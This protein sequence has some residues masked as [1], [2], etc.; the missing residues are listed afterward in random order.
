MSF[1][2]SSTFTLHGVWNFF[3]NATESC[4]VIPSQ[5]EMVPVVV[6]MVDRYL[7]CVENVDYLAEDGVVFTLVFLADQL[8]VP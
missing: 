3:L 2:S 8:N 5:T 1:L 7:C 4:A 6:V